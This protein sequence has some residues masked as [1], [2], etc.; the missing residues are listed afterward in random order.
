[1]A[2]WLMQ[3]MVG[4]SAGAVEALPLLEFQGELGDGV[5]AA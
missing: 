4:L 5:A 1:M 3:K 2:S